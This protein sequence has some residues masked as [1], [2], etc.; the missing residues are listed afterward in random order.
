M[1]AVTIIEL[2]DN[3]IEYSCYILEEEIIELKSNR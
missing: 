2:K 1:E 3:Y